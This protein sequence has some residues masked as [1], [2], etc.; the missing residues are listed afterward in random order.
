MA[1]REVCAPSVGLLTFAKLQVHPG[2]MKEGSRGSKPGETPG[3]TAWMACTPEGCQR[4]SP[5]L[6]NDNYSSPS[7]TIKTHHATGLP[8]CCLPLFCSL[9]VTL[10]A[11]PF[12][13]AESLAP[14]GAKDA[15]EPKGLA[16]A[17]G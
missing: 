5:V 15:A 13:G 9:S 10:W 12:G 11:S 1:L 4:G 2:G 6:V 8:F 14:P 7:V 16:G 17:P 3:T